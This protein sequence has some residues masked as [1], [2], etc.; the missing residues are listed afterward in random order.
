MPRKIYPKRYKKECLACD[1]FEANGGFCAVCSEGITDYD[2]RNIR[3]I[4]KL[5]NKLDEK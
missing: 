3:K 2:K 4:L 1:S 5:W